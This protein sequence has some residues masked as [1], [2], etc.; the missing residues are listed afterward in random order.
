[1]I[2]RQIHPTATESKKNYDWF[3]FNVAHKNITKKEWKG[4]EPVLI[5]NVFYYAA[6]CERLF[7]MISGR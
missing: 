3:I 6:T 7:K 2:I 1:M 5:A 4:I